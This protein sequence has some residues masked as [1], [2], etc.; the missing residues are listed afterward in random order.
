MPEKTIPPE[1]LEKIR[2][3][4]SDLLSAKFSRCFVKELANTYGD[5]TEN[6]IMM[7]FSIGESFILPGKGK[8]TIKEGK[9]IAPNKV[10]LIDAYQKLRICTDPKIAE[11][12]REAKK[13]RL[14]SRDYG[15]L[16]GDPKLD[17]M[18]LAGEYVTGAKGP[19]LDQMRTLRQKATGRKTRKGKKP[20]SRRRR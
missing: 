15:E 16:T 10:L 17:A 11:G 2:H 19:P 7:D 1:L 6:S 14:V 3:P 13:L 5:G 20:R 8:I 4:G 12:I 18:A 9:I